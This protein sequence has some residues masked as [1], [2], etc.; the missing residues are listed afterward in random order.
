MHRAGSLATMRIINLTSENV[1]AVEEVAMLVV[2]GFRDT[3]SDAWSNLEDALLEVRES[4]QSGRIS[5]VAVD[6][7]GDV[8]GWVGGIAE[9]GGNVWEL[10]PL[11]VRQDCRGRG[12]GRA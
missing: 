10:H 2:E 3:G 4:L 5:R 8:Q 11:V 7:A 9:Y 6:E 1:R 12:V